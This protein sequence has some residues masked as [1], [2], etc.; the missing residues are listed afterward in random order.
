MILFYVSVYYATNKTCSSSSTYTDDSTE[1][2]TSKTLCYLY[3]TF[4]LLYK[5]V[6]RQMYTLYYLLS[7]YH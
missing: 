1:G 2:N 6:F 5:I 4:F 3:C 7:V